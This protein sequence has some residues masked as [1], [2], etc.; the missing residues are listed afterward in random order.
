[1]I[2]Y[3]QDK[4]R[5]MNKFTRTENPLFSY[6]FK[7]IARIFIGR[8]LYWSKWWIRQWSLISS[9]K[10]KF[11]HVNSGFK[12]WSGSNTVQWRIYK[13]KLWMPT[14]SRSNFCHFHAV[15]CKIW[16]NNRL[17]P[18]EKSWIRPCKWCICQWILLVQVNTH[19]SLR[20]PF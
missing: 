3:Y 20:I 17:V 16:R 6:R 5:N 14:P 15:F 7:N 11:K 18:P 19:L 2:S 4:L 12:L 10:Y 9:S 1:M 13:V 8:R